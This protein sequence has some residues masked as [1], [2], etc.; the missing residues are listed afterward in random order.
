MSSAEK[1]DDKDLKIIS[2]LKKDS[3]SSLREIAKEVDLSPSSVRN[4]M[5]RLLDLSFIE[6]YTIDVDY[7]KLGF[8]IQVMILI[9][10]RPGNSEHLHEV[11][12]NYDE[13]SEIFWTAGPADFVCIVRVHNMKELSQFMIGKL[14]KLDGVQKIESMFLI[15]KPD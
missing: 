14:E 7:R 8:E 6:R 13:V 2:I 1:I 9:T 12:S 10:A 3:R 11:L 5:A 15:P 4:R